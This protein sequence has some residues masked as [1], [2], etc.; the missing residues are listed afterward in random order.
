MSNTGS[1]HLMRWLSW[2]FFFGRKFRWR[3][4]N[5]TFRRRRQ[6]RREVTG[7]WQ[8]LTCPGARPGRSLRAPGGNQGRIYYGE[9]EAKGREK[10]TAVG[11]PC[12]L[13]LPTPGKDEQSRAWINLIKRPGADTAERRRRRGPGVSH[14]REGTAGRPFYR[15][16]PALARP[17]PSRRPWATREA[18]ALPEKGRLRPPPPPP[19]RPR[20]HEICASPTPPPRPAPPGGFSY[21]VKGRFR[22][23][24]RLLCRMWNGGRRGERDRRGSGQSRLAAKK[25]PWTLAPPSPPGPPSPS[26][27]SVLRRPLPPLPLTPGGRAHRPSHRFPEP[28]AG[29]ALLQPPPSRRAR[30]R[31]EKNTYS[32][33]RLGV[34]LGCPPRSLP[35]PPCP[36]PQLLLAL[37]SPHTLTHTHNPFSPPPVVASVTSSSWQQ[38]LQPGT[39]EPV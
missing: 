32:A 24:P 28:S 30:G 35:F 2:A 16:K 6:G 13:D 36:L 39:E 5:P 20:R 34:P 4:L 9:R 29:P 18:A 31:G 14:V 12:A 21:L 19:A 23:C 26:M 37:P 25:R 33:P 22:G 8:V 17:R 3:A 7:N 27:T 1:P 10:N 15:P 38:E 11:N